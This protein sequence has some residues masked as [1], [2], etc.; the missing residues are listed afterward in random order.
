MRPTRL[1]LTVAL[2]GALA[3]SSPAAAQ[4]IELAGRVTASRTVLSQRRVGEPRYVA[5]SDLFYRDRS[6]LLEVLDLT[7]QRVVQV[8]ARR[9]LFERR[10][11]A[12]RG[13]GVSVPQ[14]EIA[15]FGGGIVG[16]ALTETTAGPARRAWYAELDAV[17]GK[18]VRTAGLATLGAGEQLEIIG[19]DPTGDAAWFAITLVDGRR[20]ALALRRLDL[21]TL[22]VRDAQRI[23]LPLRTTAGHEHAVT[24]HAAADFSRFAI[25]EYAEDGV[26]MAPGHVYIVDPAAGTSLAVPAPPTTYGVAFAPD[27]RYVYL[28]SAQQGTISRVNLAAGRIDKQVAAPRYLHHLVV[29]PSGTRLFA[30]ASSNRYAVYDLP[31][32]TARADA[33]HAPGVAPAMAQLS[34]HGVASLDGAYFVVPEP[35]DRRQVA[36]R[37]RA[38][39]IARLVD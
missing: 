9:A 30:L 7:T 34:G 21:A 26:R 36:A 33:T 35:D 4:R 31:D 37:E 5:L 20:R 10:F 25:V 14:G 11:G 38:Y 16:L 3:L 29:S 19:A 22:E 17:T 1:A 24:V 12:A 8:Q 18:L 2:L 15:V 23:E 27:G 39:V 6:A 13:G 28:G 32:L